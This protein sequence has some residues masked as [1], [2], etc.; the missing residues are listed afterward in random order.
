MDNFQN[1]LILAPHTDDG[2]FGCGASIAKFISQNN[3]VYYAAFS[4]AEESVPIGFPKNILEVEVKAATKVLGIK[5]DHLILYKY[6][7]RRFAQFRQEILED[8]VKLN[9]EIIPDLVFM[10]S[11]NDLHQDH[12][13]VANEGLRAFKK[14]SIL[15]YELPWNNISF[16]TN[17]FINF[18]EK[19]LETKLR[20]LNCYD[21]QKMRSY[22]SEEFIRSLAVTRGTQIGY[23]YAEV[24]EVIRWLIK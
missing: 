14:T 23:K 22:A 2:E 8:L 21:S 10:P 4:L 12:S 6:P 11:L 19:E 13:T 9:K 20:A 1:I 17:C 15:C 5:P 3:N 7:V 24:F 18:G 16:S